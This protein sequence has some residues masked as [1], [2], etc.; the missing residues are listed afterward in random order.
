MLVFI[1]PKI[2]S[3][4]KMNIN[5]ASRKLA[6]TIIYVRNEVV[7]G[8]RDLRIK[9]NIDDNFYSISEQ[10]KMSEGFSSEEYEEKEIATFP[11]AEGI[12]IMISSI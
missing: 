6:G 7:F 8:K 2:A 12:A 3:S 10:V 9:Y 4:T 11:L 5:E 1:V